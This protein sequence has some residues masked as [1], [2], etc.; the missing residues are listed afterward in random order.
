LVYIDLSISPSGDIF[1]SV[2]FTSPSPYSN[3]CCPNFESNLISMLSQLKLVSWDLFQAL[4][5]VIEERLVGER[6]TIVF[7]N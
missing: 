6:D 7:G 2:V 1:V 4:K 5:L 3:S